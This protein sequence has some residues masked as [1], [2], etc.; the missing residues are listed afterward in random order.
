M[1]KI[2]P[3]GRGGGLLPA[4]DLICLFIYKHQINIFN[5]EIFLTIYILEMDKNE[6][7]IVAGYK[8]R[9]CT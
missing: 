3:G 1:Y 4:Q 5:D 2:P 6:L 9:N 8:C 7:Y